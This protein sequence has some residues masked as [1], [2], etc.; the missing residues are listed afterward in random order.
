MYVMA[1]SLLIF[2]CVWGP[3]TDVVVF[4]LVL[5]FSLRACIVNIINQILDK[6][7]IR[8]F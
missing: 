1:G 4:F 7:V 5:D 6:F 2:C 3:E 8:C